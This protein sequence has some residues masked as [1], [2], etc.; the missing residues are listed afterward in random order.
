MEHG[1]DSLSHARCELDALRVRE[2]EHLVVVEHRVHVLDPEGVHWPVEHHPLVVVDFLL[3]AV[4]HDGRHETVGP[5]T[6]RE[7][8]VQCFR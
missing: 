1:T 5:L 6:C 4:T 8:K 7:Q 3:T 2:A